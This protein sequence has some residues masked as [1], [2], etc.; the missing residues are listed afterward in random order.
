LTN[1]GSALRT[2]SAERSGSEEGNASC[3]LSAF[4]WRGPT[5]EFNRSDA[6]KHVAM[7][8]RGGALL[9]GRDDVGGGCQTGTGLSRFQLAGFAS[10]T[11]PAAALARS[12]LPSSVCFGENCGCFRNLNWLCPWVKPERLKI[13]PIA[14][15][16][17]PND[18]R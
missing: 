16:V 9:L 6:A 12:S 18:Q 5:I 7:A 15:L 13:L 8:T 3:A 10:Q 1:S 4:G 2:A 17:W 14:H 11:A